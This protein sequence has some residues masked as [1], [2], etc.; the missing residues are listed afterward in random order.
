MPTKVP[1]Y[2]TAGT[3]I[4]AYGPKEVAQ[5]SYA[6]RDEWALVVAERD[7]DCLKSAIKRIAEDLDLRDRLRKKAIQIAQKN[8]DAIVVRTSFQGALRSVVNPGREEVR[9][10]TRLAKPTLS[11]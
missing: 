4:L 2:L 6:V 1:A 9:L 11:H 5:I 7:Q 3:P 8:H 10:T